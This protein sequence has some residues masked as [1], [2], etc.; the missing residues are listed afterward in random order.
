[1]DALLAA[2]P[3]L[4][5]YAWRIDHPAGVDIAWAHPPVHTRAGALKRPQ[6]AWWLAATWLRAQCGGHLVLAGDAHLVRSPLA[7]CRQ[8]SWTVAY[9]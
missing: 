8:W 2:H 6:D 1:M 4:R 3:L 5:R 9:G 7:A